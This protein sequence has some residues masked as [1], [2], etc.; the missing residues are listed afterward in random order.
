MVSFVTQTA[1]AGLA[2][3]QMFEVKDFGK[4]KS[5]KEVHKNLG[6]RVEEPNYFISNILFLIY[7][8]YIYNISH[9][10]VFSLLIV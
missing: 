6:Y 9:L 3:Q 5:T 10:D 1:R 4:W 2:S 8:L 7:V